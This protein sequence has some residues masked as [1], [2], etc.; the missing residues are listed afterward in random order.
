MS[1]S[2]LNHEKSSNVNQFLFFTLFGNL[3]NT[4]KVNKIQIDITNLEKKSDS[5]SV[6]NI[7][8]NRSN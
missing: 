5:K 3:L 4:S 8:L 2:R 7:I 1:E 6:N